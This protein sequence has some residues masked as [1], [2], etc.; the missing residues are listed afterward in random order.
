MKVLSKLTAGKVD[1]FEPHC[2]ARKSFVKSNPVRSRS[3]SGG[4]ISLLGG[5]SVLYYSL[6]S[7]LIE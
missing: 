7:C 6:T 2:V 4:A 3:G 1:S 5:S